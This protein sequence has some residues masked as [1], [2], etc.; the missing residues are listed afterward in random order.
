MFRFFS[1]VRIRFTVLCI[2]GGEIER[3]LCNLS[4]L[5]S[6]IGGDVHLKRVFAILVPT[7][8]RSDAIS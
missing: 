7:Q 6:D 5:S 4:S 2:R 8:V 1:K 3:D